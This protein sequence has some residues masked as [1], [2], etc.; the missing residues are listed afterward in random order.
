MPT[1]TR[2]N[3]VRSV[4]RGGIGGAGICEVTCS[5]MNREARHTWSMSTPCSMPRPVSPSHSTSAA[6]RCSVQAT[7]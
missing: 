7:G 1:G 3:A 5:S 6:T 4:I 2:L